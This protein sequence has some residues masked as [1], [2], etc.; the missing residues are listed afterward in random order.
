MN[1][2]PA[3]IGTAAFAF[4]IFVLEPWHQRI[5]DEIFELKNM[6]KKLEERSGS[7]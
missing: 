6:V 5:S 3:I 2:Y 7:R 1:K 4:Q